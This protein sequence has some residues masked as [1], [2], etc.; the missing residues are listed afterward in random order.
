[1]SV[2]VAAQVEEIETCV[3]APVIRRQGHTVFSGCDYST[4]LG[5]LHV[6]IDKTMVS[7]QKNV[8]PG[9]QKSMS[10]INIVFIQLYFGTLIAFKAGSSRSLSW[11]CVLKV[12][13]S[14]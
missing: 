5:N 7:L 13:P 9:N 12:R 10:L 1:M 3:Q 8:E 6:S 11:G 14:T 4:P 2:K